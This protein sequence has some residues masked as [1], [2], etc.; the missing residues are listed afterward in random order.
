M[1]KYPY[2]MITFPSVHHALRFES[3]MKETGISF[4]LVPV[5]REISSSCGVAARVDFVEEDTL[6]DTVDNLKLEYDSIYIYDRP[7]EKP[8]LV[9]RWEIR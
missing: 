7:K 6:V 8:S 3:K 5:P 4:Q 9:K 1:K 2:F